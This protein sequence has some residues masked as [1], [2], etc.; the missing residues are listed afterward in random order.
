[1]GGKAFLDTMEGATFP[2][3]DTQTYQR[4]KARHLGEIKRVYRL[5]DSPR[6]VPEKADH[7]DIDFIVCSPIIEADRSEVLKTATGATHSMKNGS[8]YNLAILLDGEDVSQ[9]Y[10]QVDVN[11]C[12]NEVAWEQMLSFQSYGDLGMILGL[13]ARANGLTLSLH[14]LKVWD[15]PHSSEYQLG[16][17]LVSA[18]FPD[19]LLFF[20]LDIKPWRDGFPT[21]HSIFQWVASSHWFDCRF[22]T[23]NPSRQHRRADRK[24]YRGFLAW[25]HEQRDALVEQTSNAAGHNEAD[26]V[27]S[28]NAGVKGALIFFGK[29]L[30]YDDIIA[31]E[32]RRRDVKDKFNGHLV[33]EW[34]GLRGKQVKLLMDEVRKYLDAVMMEGLTREEIRQLVLKTKE[35]MALTLVYTRPAEDVSVI[36]GDQSCLLSM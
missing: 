5:V 25:V 36:C 24:M 6:E 10:Y 13:L 8:S 28:D 35:E 14:G 34:T 33:M 30:E 17:F 3:M 1:M 21:V 23:D 2:R 26:A 9:A 20:G 7:G 12:E 18:S 16:P 22:I 29:T 11:E 32:R 27:P 15:I 4:L 31:K 19:I